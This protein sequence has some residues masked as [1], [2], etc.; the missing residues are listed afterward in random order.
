MK[1]NIRLLSYSLIITAILNS[2]QTADI[3][4]T[5]EE[6]QTYYQTW[7]HYMGDPARTHYSS[8]GE[9]DRDNVQEL[10]V[11]WTYESGE[12]GKN[13]YI[14]CN[15]LVVDTILYGASPGMKIFAVHAAT[16]EPIW[17]FNPFE[18]TN[19]TSFTRGLSYWAE[20]DDHRLYFTAREKLYALDALTGKPVSAFGGQGYIDLREGLGR[21]IEG[22]AYTYHSPGTIYQDLIIMGALNAERLPA[23]PGHIRAFNVRTG[24]QAWIFHTIPQP[25]QEGY[26]TW[27]DSTAYRYI[28]GVN[29]WA[30]M[31]LDEERGIV[32]APLGSASFDFYGGNR[33]GANLYANSLVALDAR[34]GEKRWHFQTVHHDIWDRDLPSPPTLVAVEQEGEKIDA[35][36]QITKSGF[37]YVFNRETGESLFPIEEQPYPESDLIGEETWP[38]QP[39]PTQPP[40]FARQSM[41]ADDI[42]PHSRFRD[43]LLAV[44]ESVRSGGQFEPPSVEGTIIFPGLDGGGEWG[45]A[46]YDPVTGVLYV[47]ANE[48]PWILRMIEQENEQPKN[49]MA[50]GQNVYQSNCVGCHGAD[51]EGSTF[52]GQAPALVDLAERMNEEQVHERVREGK[53]AMPSFAYL[54]DIQIDAVTAYLLK[55]EGSSEQ[56][57]QE[58]SI[59]DAGQL[60][61]SFEGYKSFSDADGY[62]AV[63][64]PWGTMNAIDLNK[65]KIL[66]Q[67]PLG[68]YP[69]LTEKGIPKTGTN[70]YGGPVVTA[71][72]LVF[73]AATQDSQIRAFNSATG[74]ELWKHALPAAGMATPCT[75]EVDGKQYIVIA[76][77]GGKITKKHGDQYVAFALPDVMGNDE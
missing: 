44:F 37:V 17:E 16:G 20:G 49:L 8:L 67:V 62:P 9:I 70:N 1:N 21:D 52:H 31:T 27:E 4:E 14:Q 26:E 5:A 55:E 66:W 38:T 25:G 56:I 29:N 46:G 69:E 75:Y 10:E 43:S 76:A 65:G 32:F 51:L 41:T 35:V 63:K 58:A 24:E 50:L 57:V 33:K 15:P 36:A 68:E 61:Y 39:L 30:G 3:T 11:A 48:L 23:A 19:Q 73:I 22:L 28:G 6:H 77:G 13:N 45:G 74:E 40:P 60:R 64:P 54:S 12:I 2:C 72:G 71:G 42:N 53:G 59:N 18:G 7:S 47:N 34:T